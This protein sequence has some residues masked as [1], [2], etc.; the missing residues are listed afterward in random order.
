MPSE[1]PLQKLKSFAVKYRSSIPLRD[2]ICNYKGLA[3]R[4]LPAV[5]DLALTTGLLSS[6][7]AGARPR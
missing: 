2:V 1:P 5:A 3:L 4:W 7:F 6:D